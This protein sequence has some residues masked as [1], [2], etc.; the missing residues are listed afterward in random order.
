MAAL[1]T[2]GHAPF[3]RLRTWFYGRRSVEHGPITLGHRRVYIMPTRT[4]MMFAATLAIMLVGSINYVLSLGFMLTFLLAGLALAGMVHTVRN[5]AR[6]VV[7]SGRAEA[8][9]AGE[10]AQ[11]R[12]FIENPAPWVRPAVMVRHDES[13]AQTV[14]DIPASATADVVLPLP[15]A[16][17]GWLELGRVSLETRYPIGLFRAW[18]HVQP[19]FRCLV[20]PRPEKAPLP[21][22][23]PDASFGSRQAATQGTDDFSSLRTYQP[24]DS[25]RHVAWKAV[26]RSDDMLTKQFTGDASA[27]LWLDWSL[28]PGA[29]ELEARL[30]RLAGWVLACEAEGLRYGL[31]IPGVNIPPANGDTH[32]TACLTALALFEPAGIPGAR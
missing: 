10:S 12:L 32:R 18:S 22:A 29:L 5:L 11:F 31:R 20:Y 19:D 25:P 6:L 3:S 24:A 2:A 9:F 15:A 17:R 27:E 4:G 1:L 8:V 30:S 26:A 21:A 23:S 14:T 7:V 13:G 28:L 16:R